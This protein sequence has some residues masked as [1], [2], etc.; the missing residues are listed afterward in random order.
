MQDIVYG[1]GNVLG[2]LACKTF[3]EFEANQ[4]DRE[5]EVL[6]D[7]LNIVGLR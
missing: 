2:V 4:V 6:Q 3:R 5:G 7:I 1:D